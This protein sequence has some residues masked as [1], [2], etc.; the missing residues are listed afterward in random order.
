M[1][2]PEAARLATENARSDSEKFLA[3]LP[4]RPRGK[5]IGEPIDETNERIV[6]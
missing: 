5:E 1:A 3:G 4:F 2:Y 6:P